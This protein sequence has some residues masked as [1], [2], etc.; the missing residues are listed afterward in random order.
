MIIPRKEINGVPIS[1]SKVRKLAKNGE[2][3]KIKELVP[4]LTLQYLKE[5]YQ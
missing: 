3:D 1:A 4:N 5:K 2:F